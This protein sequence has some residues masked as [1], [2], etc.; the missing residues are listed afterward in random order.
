MPDMLQ[1]PRTV[2]YSD[3]V[4]QVRN[5][6]EAKAIILTPQPGLS[7]DQRWRSETPYFGQLIRKHVPDFAK[8]NTLLDYGCGI[9][10]MTLEIMHDKIAYA[11]GVDT[12][13]QMRALSFDYVRDPR[14]CVVDP[15][16][17]RC[18][19]KGGM[20][21]NI[22]LSVWALQHILEVEDAVELLRKSL[23][24]LGGCLFVVNEL[25]RYIPTAPSP[26]LHEWVDDGKDVRT[27]L[28]SRCK[29][30]IIEGKLDPLIVTQAVSD[31]TF[32]GVYRF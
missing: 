5:Q 27:L 11:V 19:N 29:E 28:C 16:V 10:R 31:K 15:A 25:Q 14:F 17:L 23:Q 24:I 6:G 30:V 1:Q 9:G 22:A 7:V 4:F 12:S 2:Q 3:A 13:W 21:F 8:R 18:F 32:W 20:D 26:G